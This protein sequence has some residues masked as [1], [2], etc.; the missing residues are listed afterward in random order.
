MGQRSSAFTAE[1]M[2][3]YLDL[4][5]LSKGE[6]LRAYENFLKMDPIKVTQNRQARIPCDRIRSSTEELKL[7]PFG[8]RICKVF[9][10][11]SDGFMTFD[12][13][14]DMYSAMS[15]DA[16]KD[17]KTSFAFRIYDFDGDG[18]IG[19]DDI[20]CAVDRLLYNDDKHL[21][22]AETAGLIDSLLH[23][24]DNDEDGAI[25]YPEFQQAMQKCPDFI[26]N[27]KMYV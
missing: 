24:V 2:E 25:C 27:F 10:S 23:E 13:Y 1:E 11:R 22:K 9:S 17:V 8:D 18:V 4:T 15:E 20:K 12:D 21:T 6:I 14:L 19:K 26:C 7:N 3:E 5:Y 16:S